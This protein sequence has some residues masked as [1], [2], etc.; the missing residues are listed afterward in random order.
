MKTEQKR[1]LYN[2]ECSCRAH[3]GRWILL[4][5][6]GK[7]LCDKCEREYFAVRR[8]ESVSLAAMEVEQGIQVS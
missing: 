4:H 8:D 1:N 6:D 3:I 5:V 2:T 7:P